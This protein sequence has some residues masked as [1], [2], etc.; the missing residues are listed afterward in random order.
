MMIS[1]ARGRVAPQGDGVGSLGFDLSQIFS[2]NNIALCPSCAS[3]V[4][5]VS[6]EVVICPC[7]ADLVLRGR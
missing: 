1:E 6:S 2:Q 3:E 5:F 4:E 7:D